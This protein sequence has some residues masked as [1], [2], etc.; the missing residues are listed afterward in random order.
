[1]T[2]EK[3]VRFK[4]TMSMKTISGILNVYFPFELK[5]DTAVLNIQRA[6]NRIRGSQIKRTRY[7]QHPRTDLMDKESMRRETENMIV[8]G[9]KLMERHDRE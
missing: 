7:M 4:F 3:Q 1:M 6:Y 8:I 2:F 5:N 9:Q